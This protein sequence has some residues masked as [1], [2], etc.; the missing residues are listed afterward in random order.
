VPDAVRALSRT[1]IGQGQDD[2]YAI[3]EKVFQEASGRV[4][5]ADMTQ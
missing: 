4:P 5:G 1:S 2:A 3:Y